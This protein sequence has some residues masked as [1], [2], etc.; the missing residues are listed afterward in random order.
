MKR[1]AAFWRLAVFDSVP[2]TSD[3]CRERAAA[4][5]PAGFAVRANQQSAGRGSRGREWLSEPG[6]LALSA[7]LRPG[8]PSR[9]AGLWALLAGV[10]VAEAL[11]RPG[12]ALKW[13]NDILL[14]DAK[15]GGILIETADDGTGRLAW[16]V[17]GIG[18]NLASAPAINGRLVAALGDGEAE[19]LATRI[20]DR[21]SHW[22]EAQQRQGWAVVRDAWLRLALPVGCAMSVRQGERAVHGH[23]AGL[24][25]DGSLRLE[26][27]GRVQAFSSGEIWL[28]QEQAAC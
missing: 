3:L 8:T 14:G 25:D 4:G 28:P 27:D 22:Q 1:A 2:S 11:G 24:G 21:L 26:Q 18:I 9:E 13:P 17:I 6:N 12:I 5:E 10:A 7:L 23:F 15:L 20:L 16:L 19:G